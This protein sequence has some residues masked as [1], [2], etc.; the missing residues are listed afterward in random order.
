MAVFDQEGK[1]G[2][3][4]R[5]SERREG[6][7]ERLSVTQEARNKVVVAEVVDRRP[8]E[9]PADSEAEED[10][11]ESFQAGLGLVFQ[12]HVCSMNCGRAPIQLTAFV[13]L[14]AKL[15]LAMD[16]TQSSRPPG[17]P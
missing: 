6:V 10:D 1:S 9:R 17:S 2:C 8:Q 7:V 15:H 13:S 4:R 12:H 3:N 11:K 16:Q 14:L 5:A